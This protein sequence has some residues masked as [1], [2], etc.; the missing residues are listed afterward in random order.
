[1]RNQPALRTSSGRVWLVVGGILAV[2]CMVVLLAQLRNSVPLAVIG[3][4][5]VA[6]LYAAM[7]LVRY[8]VASPPRLVVLACVF[9]AIPVWAIV[10]IFVIVAQV[11]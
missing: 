11:A 2:V 9:A 7:I 10:W 3:A 5:V 8:L 6:L 4:I 1:V